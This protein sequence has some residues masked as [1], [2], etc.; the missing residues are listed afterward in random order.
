[1]LV[2]GAMLDG[3][4]DTPE[5]LLVEQLVGQIREHDRVYVATK[6]QWYRSNQRGGS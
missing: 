2:G 5:V 4:W 3:L 6:L 1:V